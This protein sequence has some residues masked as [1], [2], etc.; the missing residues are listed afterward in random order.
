MSSTITPGQRLDA[1]D[2]LADFRRAAGKPVIADLLR[3]LLAIQPRL[4]ADSIDAVMVSR[5][6]GTLGAMAIDRDPDFAS[7]AEARE[8]GYTRELDRLEHPSA[9]ALSSFIQV[10]AVDCIEAR[11]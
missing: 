4:V 6:I 2:L 3:R 10:A 11:A 7:E 1:L 8:L 9:D 5:A